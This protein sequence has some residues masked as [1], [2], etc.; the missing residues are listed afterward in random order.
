MPDRI[1]HRGVPYICAAARYL[2]DALVE[3]LE[4]LDEQPENGRA[5]G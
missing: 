5:G 3:K 1:V 4:T 2:Y